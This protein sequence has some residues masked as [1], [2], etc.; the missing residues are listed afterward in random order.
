MVLLVAVAAAE[1]VNVVGVAPAPG[2]TEVMT[3]L[4]GMPAPLTSSPTASP[5][6]VLGTV[7][8]V[9]EAKLALGMVSS[10]G[11]AVKAL[12]ALLAI[13]D[14]PNTFACEAPEVPAMAVALE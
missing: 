13:E 12:L 7:I 10:A 14:T 1:I 4:A 11:A 9:D 5:V 8:V 3:A 2:V 6:V